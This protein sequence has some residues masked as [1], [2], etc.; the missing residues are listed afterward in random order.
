MRQK[1][2]DAKAPD[3]LE[4]IRKQYASLRQSA[5]MAVEDTY[6]KMAGK[7]KEQ[8]E[9]YYSGQVDTAKVF[10]PVVFAP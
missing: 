9:G 8:L 2:M 10:V 6:Q 5:L 1:E 3:I 7:V 4:K